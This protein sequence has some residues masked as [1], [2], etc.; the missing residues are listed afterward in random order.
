MVIKLVRHIKEEAIKA[1]IT[2]VRMAWVSN[3]GYLIT[4]SPMQIPVTVD[5]V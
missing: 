5:P 3:Y 2:D 4:K 1:D